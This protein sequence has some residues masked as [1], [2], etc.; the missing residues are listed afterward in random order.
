[1]EKK[2]SNNLL[3]NIRKFANN[4]LYSK[5]Y[6]V[7]TNL[8]FQ[9]LF[10]N[11][12]NYK[13]KKISSINRNNN[14]IKRIINKNLKKYNITSIKFYKKIVNGLI[15]DGK[16]HLISL[17]KD[18]LFLYDEIECLKR[19]YYKNEVKKK[20]KLFIK[21]YLN[22]YYKILYYN[23]Y[24]RLGDCQNVIKNYYKLKA[25]LQK[26][27][28]NSKNNNIQQTNINCNYKNEEK[29]INTH[30]K[31]N[32]NSLILSKITPDEMIINYDD[33]QIKEDKL[34]NKYLNNKNLSLKNNKEK[35]YKLRNIINLNLSYDET[36]N[37]LIKN[38]SKKNVDKLKDK[39][40]T[41][42]NNINYIKR[43][44][45]QDFQLLKF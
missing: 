44:N 9:T 14:I 39:K 34:K 36:I 38:L 18:Y 21:Y 11:L 24:F 12:N 41:N 8:T 30:L 19:Y 40:I 26:E 17:F 43:N 33:F 27:L 10:K 31:F 42:Q 25:K 6:Y 13:N 4:N 2:F 7:K 5:N 28:R 3:Y 20:I 45:I 22:S 15:F 37:S 35:K 32:S 16:S 29:I 23:I 1:M